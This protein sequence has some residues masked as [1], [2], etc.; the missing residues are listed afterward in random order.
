[1]V[2]VCALQSAGLSNFA[3]GHTCSRQDTLSGLA[4]KYGVTPLAIKMTNNLISD[5]GLQ[6]RHI[7]YVPGKSFVNIFQNK[8][9]FKNNAPLRTISNILNASLITN[10]TSS[11]WLAANALCA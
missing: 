11:H 7:I 3:W 9:S 1:M 10:S 4:V 8:S 6:S 2:T 5:I